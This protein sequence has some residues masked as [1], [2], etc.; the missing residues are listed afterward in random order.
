MPFDLEQ[1]QRLS[2]SKS[3]LFLKISFNL[4]CYTF[5]GTQ[6]ATKAPK[7]QVVCLG[8]MREN[9]KDIV[10]LFE[11]EQYEIEALSGLKAASKERESLADKQHRHLMYL[12]ELAYAVSIGEG[13]MSK[14]PT[15]EWQLGYFGK[16]LG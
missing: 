3:I 1:A 6:T 7:Q 16:L 11:W 13:N 8:F 5:D 12:A 2:I 10:G 9:M 14:N 4:D 15:C